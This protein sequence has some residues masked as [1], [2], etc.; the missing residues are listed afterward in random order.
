MAAANDNIFPLGVNDCK[1]VLGHNSDFVYEVPV[2]SLARYPDF[3]QHAGILIDGQR[4]LHWTCDVENQATM[5]VLNRDLFDSQ[6]FHDFI[7]WLRVARLLKPE[8]IKTKNANQHVHDWQVRLVKLYILAMHLPMQ[9]LADA[10]LREFFELGELY[11]SLDA[12]RCFRNFDDTVQRS[13]LVTLILEDTV[14]TVQNDAAK[15]K[16]GAMQPGAWHVEFDELKKTENWFLEMFATRMT[17]MANV[18]SNSDGDKRNL[19][20]F[21]KK[22]SEDFSDLHGD[23]CLCAAFM[24]QDIETAHKAMF[25]MLRSMSERQYAIDVLR[26]LAEEQLPSSSDTSLHTPSPTE[27][28]MTSRQSAPR[29]AKPQQRLPNRTPIRKSPPRAAKQSSPYRTRD[30]VPKR[31]RSASPRRRRANASEDDKMEGMSDTAS[32]NSRASS[33]TSWLGSLVTL[34]P[35]RRSQQQ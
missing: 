18:R 7:S 3:I 24:S 32:V 16:H 1:V 33:T 23:H 35:F 8:G 30:N 10:V 26:K 5:L 11:V 31:R 27:S 28:R 29:K 2:E 17:E 13:A 14:G 25:A 20:Y 15:I 6:T 22:C 19:A 34:S 21:L 4:A 9:D 12:I